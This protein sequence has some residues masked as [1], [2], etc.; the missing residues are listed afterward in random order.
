MSSGA[1][2]ELLDAL[3][4]V[5]V[6]SWIT[7]INLIQVRKDVTDA[8]I[9][10][11]ESVPRWEYD[12]VDFTASRDQLM[13][14]LARSAEWQSGFPS[15]DEELDAQLQRSL[16]TVKAIGQRDDD[17]FT[18]WSVSSYGTPATSTQEY[19]ARIL[20]DPLQ[21]AHQVSTPELTSPYSGSDAAA[22]I[23]VALDNY[24]L[25]DWR[26]KVKPSMAARM[27]VLTSHR[28]VNVDDSSQFSSAELRRLLVHEVGTH[29]LR[30]ANAWSQT[31]S[32]ARLGLG[33]SV[34]TEEGLATWNENKF[35][36]SQPFNWRQYACRVLAVESAA[37]HGVVEIAR[38]LEPILGV[39]AAASLAIRVKRGLQD[40]NAPGGFTK[41]HGYLTGY[42][43]V[44]EHLKNHP[45]DYS[46]L[47]STKWP[48]RLLPLAQILL[49][50]H[51]LTYDGLRPSEDELGLLAI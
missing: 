5:R 4:S 19:A 41:D 11:H 17:S 50:E 3:S 33:D 31:L 48:L 27:S 7:P 51:A 1:T 30:S 10:G 40:P 12:E 23:R 44:T 36:V 8:V 18:R 22:L 34:P 14:A 49:D 47:M 42:L 46:L 38:E 13:G 39:D 35:G 2:S 45:G 9:K 16:N 21:G 26:I 6:T 20:A 32:A 25:H 29:V 43:S 24:G 37:A 15:L 28:T